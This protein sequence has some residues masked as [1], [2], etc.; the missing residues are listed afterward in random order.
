MA[1]G[2]VLIIAVM[3]AAP[4][5]SAAGDRFADVVQLA[6]D[7]YSISRIDHGGIFGNAGKMKT[8]VFKEAQDF[9][10]S[11]GKVAVARHIQEQPMIAGRSFASWAL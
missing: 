3:L 9:A 11:M 7:T 6:P 5:I 8:K 2:R 4:T 10:A 1:H